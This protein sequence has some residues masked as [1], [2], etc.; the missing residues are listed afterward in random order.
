MTALFPDNLIRNVSVL[1]E[2]PS[3]VFSPHSLL[4][5]SAIAKEE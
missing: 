5:S 4:P 3:W 1:S 2:W